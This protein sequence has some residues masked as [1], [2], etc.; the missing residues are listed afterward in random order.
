MFLVA[1]AIRVAY[2]LEIRGTPLVQLLLIDSETYDRFARLI[3][4]GRFHGEEVSS[5][6]LLYPY[7][8]A[9]FYAVAGAVPWHA[10]VVQAALSAA[11][12]ALIF[13]LGRRFFDEPTAWVAGAA[14]ALYAPYVFYSGA[15]LTPTSID[16]CVLLALGALAMALRGGGAGWLLASGLATGL[17]AL[18]RGSG[19]LFAPLALVPLRT[20]APSWR[21][22]LRRWV[23][24]ALGALG[25]VGAVTLRNAIAERGF[26]PI[27]AN[28]AAFYLGHHE[29]SNGLYAMHGFHSDGAGYDDEVTGVRRELS[30]QLGR[31]LTQAEASAELFHRGIAWAGAHPRAEGRLALRKTFFFWN[32]TESPT[33]LGFDFA[34]EFSAVLRALPLHFGLVAPVGLAGIALSWRRRRELAALHIALLVPWITCVAFFVSAEY[35]MPAAAPLLLFGASAALTAGRTIHRRRERLGSPSRGSVIAALAIAAVAAIGCNVRTPLL[36]AQ[37]RHR[38]PFYDFGVLYARRGDLDRAEAMLRRSLAEDPR[39]T[40]A[41]V[42]LAGVQSRQGR[43]AEA[44]HTLETARAVDPDAAPIPAD[45]RPR[46]DAE[47]LYGQGRFAEALDGFDRAASLYARQGRV[48]DARAVR[49]NLAL[50]LHRLHR[51]GEAEA[52]LRS[53]LAEAPAYARAHANLGLVLEAQGRRTEALAAWREALRLDPANARARQ[54]LARLAGMGP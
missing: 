40:P 32:R 50:T 49:N 8:L 22:A 23:I 7:L 12:A 20:A 16:T 51:D 9:A 6:N 2:V 47:R 34:R 36:T 17:S 14:A 41:L 46:V 52:T 1:L 3:L 15:L 24:L 18:G 48:D 30:R 33:N 43:P 31:P 54:A 21:V 26:V 27:A 13:V 5:M 53:V 38:V 25:V 35:R 10:L 42:A 44:E 37:T 4:A 19:I 11:N 45:D 39:F 28:Y 29:G